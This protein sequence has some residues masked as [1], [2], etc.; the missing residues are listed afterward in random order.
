MMFKTFYLK[1]M[2]I[3]SVFIVVGGNSN[4]SI[5]AQEDQGLGYQLE[6]TSPIHIENEKFDD[7]I[8]T[9]LSGRFLAYEGSGYISIKV[10][11]PSLFHVNINGQLVD[12]SPAKMG[13]I[14]FKCYP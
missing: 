2:V 12:L 10:D 7:S 1:L 4:L 3:I 9:N 14:I 8:L 13:K 6:I 11:D 5:F